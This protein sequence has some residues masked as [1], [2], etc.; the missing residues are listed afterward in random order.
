MVLEVPVDGDPA[1]ETSWW[2]DDS[3][4]KSSDILRVS[5]AAN[6]AKLM[7]IPARRSLAGK[8]TLKAKNKHGEDSAEVQIDVFGKPSA[9]SGPLVVSDITKKTCLLSWKPPTDNGGYQISQYEVEKLDPNLDQWLPVKTTKGLSL[10]VHNLSEGKAYKFLVRAVNDLGDSPDLVTEDAIIAKN[11][12][13]P[14]SPPSKPDVV[15]W[16]EDFAEL[17][18]KQSDDSEVTSY[19]VEMRNRAKRAWTQVG[20]TKETNFRVSNNISP[21]NEYEFRV[22]ASNNGGDSEC[23]PSSKS[24]VAETRFI[25]PKI[26]RDL[27]GTEKVV[28]ANQPLRLTVEVT[29]AP[30]PEVQFYF[31]SGSDVTT[32]PA[33]CTV[34]MEENLA[35]LTIKDITRADAGSFKIVAKN[36]QGID[37]CEVRI[38]VVG[39]PSKPL[40]PLAISDV[41]P[42]G[43]KLSWKKPVDDGGSPLT[44][45]IIEKKDLDKDIWISCGK[46]VGKMVVVMKEIE[47]EVT[48][49]MEGQVYFFRVL[50]ANAQGE[51]EPLESTIPIVAKHA[52][53]PPAVPSTP[54]IVDYDKK[55]AKLEWWAPSDNNIKHYI[56]EVQERFMVPKDTAEPAEGDSESQ[57]QTEEGGEAHSAKSAVPAFT[58]EF[59]EYLSNWMTIMVTDDNTPKVTITGLGENNKYSFR[60]KAVNGAGASE[61]SDATEEITCKLRKQRPVIHRDTLTSVKVSQGQTIRLGAKVSGEPTPTKVWYYG[62]IE[63][64]ACPSVDI[65]ETE[66]SVKVTMLNAR[67]DDTGIYTLKAENEHGLDSAEVSVVVT[68][69]PSK[70]HGPM[71]IYDVYAEGCTC[72]WGPPQDDG[73]S[74][75]THYLVEKLEGKQTQWIPCGRTNGDTTVCHIMGLT[76]EKEHR[77]RVIAVNGEGQ[78]EPLAGVD[79][80]TTENPYGPPSA[81]GK[82]HM[83]GVDV[84]HFDLKWDAPKNDGGSRVTGYQLESRLWKDSVW[85]RCG[86][87]RHQLEFGE[88][89]GMELGKAYTVRVRALNAA[90]P[91]PWSVETDQLV[92]R[93]KAL[94]PKVNFREA[95]EITLKSGETLSLGVDIAAEPPAEDIVW[96]QANGKVLIASPGNGIYIDNTKPYMSFLEKEGVNRKDSGPIICTASN[97]H[98]KSSAQIMLNV[99]SRPSMPQDRLIVSNVHRN[100]CRLSWKAPADDGG[101]PLEYIIEKFVVDANAWTRCATTS[102]T[103]FDIGDLENGREYAFAVVAFNEVGESDPLSSSKTIIAKDQFTCPL[104]PGAPHISDWSERHMGLEWKE[105]LDDGGMPITGYHLEVKASNGDDWQL[106]EVIDTN[107]TKASVQNLQS[108]IE[109]QFRVIAISKAGKSEPSLPSRPKEARAQKLAPYIDA[110]NLHDVTVVAGDR[111]KFDLRIFGEPTP[112]VVWTKE[113]DDQ[114]LSS[115]SDRNLIITDTE[116]NTKF[117]INNVKKCHAGRYT[118][119]VSNASGSDSAKGEI[120]VLDRPSPPE[121]LQTSMEGGNCILIWKKSKDDG[122]AP[123]EHYQV[124]KFETEKGSWMACGKTHD[125]TFQAKGLL[126]GHEYR[127]RVSAVNEHGDSDPAEGRSSVIVRSENDNIDESV[128]N[129]S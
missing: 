89:T 47:H 28:H 35:S 69:A 36:S 13:D 104:A 63:I 94:K 128:R 3:E 64:K 119:T 4:V 80:F 44:A 5:H 12:F 111:V 97:M 81:P 92:C 78:S 106:C 105:P 62:K 76:P 2:K 117:V 84:D 129:L 73:D 1:P 22:I 113:G 32:D 53:D 125:N 43:C 112:E 56:V 102:S 8:Y 48:G 39:T 93:H 82:P 54:R 33:R 88:A 127:F 46:T 40:G 74:P 50:A 66:T 37:E 83:V 55:S 121:D 11:P 10:E 77:L 27:L 70:P 67:R 60:I 9:P 65:T 87:V 34:E 95:K 15:D 24:I 91:G 90:G 85:I 126:P 101:L 120:R 6:C 99:L 21:E 71:K 26:N 38:D 116:T 7:F 68:V 108:G 42:N 17:K 118:V 124:E 29:A 72:E 23:S 115:S 57:A 79:S 14:P 123:I 45:Y 107:Q 41:N 52:L 75:I 16:G 20:I 51:G 109:Y 100:G 61:P 98:G 86:E 25:K 49:L 122:G 30:K 110:K 96:S 59:Q 114:P 19:K 103:T 18:W 31:P 58:G